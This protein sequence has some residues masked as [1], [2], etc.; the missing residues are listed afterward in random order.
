M[1]SS[2]PPAMME[3]LAWVVAKLE[4]FHLGPHLLLLLLPLGRD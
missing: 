2:A 4:A 3:R 1:V